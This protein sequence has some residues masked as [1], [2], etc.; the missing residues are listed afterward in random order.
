MAELAVRRLRT[1]S[2][3]KVYADPEFAARRVNHSCKKLA[4]FTA[5]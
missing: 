3:F 1:Q 4:R 5:S 2:Y